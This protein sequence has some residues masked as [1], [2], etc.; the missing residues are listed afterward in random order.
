MKPLP[1]HE[2][3]VVAFKAAKTDLQVE[4][5]AK[6]IILTKIP[7]NHDEITEAYKKAVI[8]PSSDVLEHLQEQKEIAEKKQKEADEKKK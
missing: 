1:F 5:L 8:V 2:S 4:C 6:L 3:I 7:E